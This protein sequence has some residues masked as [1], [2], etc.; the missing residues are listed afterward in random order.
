MECHYVSLGTEDNA[1]ASALLANASAMLHVD[2]IRI[3]GVPEQ[4]RSGPHVLV[5]HESTQMSSAHAT[6]TADIEMTYQNCS[7]VNPSCFMHH[8]E[9]TSPV[10]R[11]A[12]QNCTSSRFLVVWVCMA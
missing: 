7:Q 10:G 1:T 9:D 11:F 2:D 5:I 6:H 3:Q 12:Q 8:R 4:L